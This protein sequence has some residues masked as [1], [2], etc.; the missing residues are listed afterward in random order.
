VASYG[1]QSNL[2]TQDDSATQDV[3]YM[4]AVNGN[5][6]VYLPAG[7]SAYEVKGIYGYSSNR[8]SG[9]VFNMIG[10]EGNVE[11]FEGSS[12]QVAHG[13]QSVILTP[14]NATTNFL[15]N[16]ALID[17]G[18]SQT[19]HA[20]HIFGLYIQ[21]LSIS[22]T[23]PYFLYYDSPGVYDVAGDGTMAY[24]NPSFTKFAPGAPNYERAVQQWNSNTLEYGTQAGGTGTLRPVRILG[25]E[26]TTPDLTVDSVL[27]L[28][29]RSSPPSSPSEG[30][31]YAGTNH[32]LYYY[33]GTA[34]KQ[35]DN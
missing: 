7:R 31:I 15:F 18:P 9:Y 21:D 16:G 29:P 10:A 13:V 27:K 26:L 19:T 34:W 20:T 4:W 6:Y 14:R 32:H 1:I 30:W 28:T 35:L 3:S 11:L 5:S 2:L 24:Y 33:D 8:G 17:P 23:Y 25:S 12:T 22:A